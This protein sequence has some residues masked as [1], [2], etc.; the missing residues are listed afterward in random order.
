MKNIN[1]YTFIQPLMGILD[2][3]NLRDVAIFQNYS[4]LKVLDVLRPEA[5]LSSLSGRPFHQQDHTRRV[6]ER[7]PL[8]QVTAV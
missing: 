5:M 4:S 1:I 8:R 7:L 3:S 6:R 2:A